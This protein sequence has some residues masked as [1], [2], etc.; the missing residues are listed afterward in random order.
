MRRGPAVLP[1]DRVVDR[2]ASLPVPED[3]RLTL[4]GDADARQIF[5]GNILLLKRFARH[6]ALRLEDFLR[7]VL[8]PAGLRIDLADFALRGADRGACA[9]R[10]TSAPTACGTSKP[11]SATSRTTITT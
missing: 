1:D 10:V 11:I 6:S 2:L 3:G 8:D 9:S 4:I 7:V 5:Q